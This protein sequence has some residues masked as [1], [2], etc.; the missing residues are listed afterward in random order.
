MSFKEWFDKSVDFID[1]KRKHIVTISMSVLGVIVLIVLLFL[2]SDELTFSKEATTLL[3]SIEQRKYNSAINYYNNI[4]KDFSEAKMNRFNNSVSKKINKLLLTNGD[5]LVTGQISKE[6]YVGLI[7]MIN[8]LERIEI[9]AKKIINQAQ[10]VTEMYREEN[11]DYDIAISY[12]NSAA[13]LNSIVNEL[14]E[15]K[16]EIKTLYESRSI[17]EQSVKNQEIKKY[18]EAITGF[19]KVLEA[20]KK[21]YNL[22]QKAKNKCIEDMYLFYIESSKESDSKGDYEKALQY[23]EYLKPYYSNDEEI[24]N[25]EKEYKKKLSLYTLSV[26][27]ILNIIT[28]KSGK[29]KESLSISSFQ[30]MIND[31]KYYYVEV[32]EYD[33]LIDEI[34]V[35]AKTKKIYSYKDSNK[36]FKTNFSDGY[37]K[38]TESGEIEFAITEGEAKFLLENKLADKGKTYKSITFVDVAK[39]DDYINHSE[40]IS[41]MFGKNKNTYYYAVISKGLFRKKEIYAIN[42]YDKKVYSITQSGAKEYK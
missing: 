35:E 23:I 9:D 13:S 27:D 8:S 34:L 42:M 41:D 37:F 38:V 32:Y 2:S 12:I 29:E 33:T 30:Q 15:F 19:D 11:V 5:K 26:D 40:S 31:E 20:D 16:Q 24:L 25:L 3:N 21:Y 6:H 28:K 4:E 14:N 17:Y 18:H 10:R 1:E 39:A 36:D 22:A 7:N